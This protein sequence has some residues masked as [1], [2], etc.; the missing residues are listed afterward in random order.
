MS[1]EIVKLQ[2][3]I[4]DVLSPEKGY[5]GRND[6]FGQ[7]PTKYEYIGYELST[8]I[9]P[10]L[11]KLGED[12]QK[13]LSR[14]V[15]YFEIHANPLKRLLMTEGKHD[16]YQFY[17]DIAWSHFMTV[18]MFGM[19]EMAVRFAREGKYSENGE[20][21]NKGET[22]KLFLENNLEQKIKD[23]IAENYVTDEIFGYKKKIETFSD[24]IDHMW[25]KIRCEFVHNGGLESKGLEWT[26]LKGLGS[27][28]N[29]ITVGQDV[30]MQEWLKI[31][32]QAILHSFGYTGSLQLPKYKRQNSLQ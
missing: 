29:P 6:T 9:L 14:I 17:A 1:E 31:T 4:I 15:T 7:R 28:E 5:F 23:E 32:W 22:I 30:P 21:L 18:T 10:T 8:D 2:T 27:K 3:A 26:T 19:L 25:R 20:L 16:L 24:V 11:E 12:S 13:D